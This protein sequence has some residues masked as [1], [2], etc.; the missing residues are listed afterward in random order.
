MCETILK[1]KSAVLKNVADY[2]Q[3][4]KTHKFVLA[5]RLQLAFFKRKFKLDQFVVKLGLTL[6]SAIAICCCF[7]SNKVRIRSMCGKLP[8][9]G[10]VSRLF[11]EVSK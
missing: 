7:L 2:S 1:F 10:R 6:H 11:Q 4:A 5:V 9:I 3:N 8:I